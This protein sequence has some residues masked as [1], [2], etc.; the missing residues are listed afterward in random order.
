MAES[1][2]LDRSTYAWQKLRWTCRLLDCWTFDFWLSTLDFYILNFA[3]SIL[4][5]T[6]S[7]GKSLSKPTRFIKPCRRFGSGY[8]LYP[9][10]S[11]NTLHG[12][13]L[14][15][16]LQ[17]LL[18]LK[19]GG[20]FQQRWKTEGVKFS[21]KSLLQKITI[22]SYRCPIKFIWLVSIK[23]WFLILKAKRSFV[24]L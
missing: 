15:S 7:M 12:M 3:F 21:L 23:S 24:R 2:L 10:S 14:L 9:C 6:F 4:N 17:K 8:P 13:P 1:G 22:F 11:A 19:G 18:T 16:L 5:F 20:G